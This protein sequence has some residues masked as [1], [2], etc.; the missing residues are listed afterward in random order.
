[1]TNLSQKAKNVQNTKT[2]PYK[3]IPSLISIITQNRFQILENPTLQTQDSNEKREDEETK[4]TG[5]LYNSKLT[6][7]KNDLNKRIESRK[8]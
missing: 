2:N 5:I 6:E 4:M 7:L 1:M 3:E 8:T